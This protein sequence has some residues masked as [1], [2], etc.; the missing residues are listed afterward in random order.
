M[1]DRVHLPVLGSPP[2][3]S[4]ELLSQDD[5]PTVMQETL[6]WDGVDCV[7]ADLDDFTEIREVLG[8]GA[9]GKPTAIDDIVQ[10]R[11]DFVAGSW[12]GLQIT[13]AF[14]D[15]VWIDTLLR[16]PDGARLLR[17]VAPA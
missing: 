11:H 15:Q 1:S 9:D 13:Y 8:R 2:R 12:H 5:L 10:A 14:A 6:D 7:L 3:S 16:E 4:D 17:M